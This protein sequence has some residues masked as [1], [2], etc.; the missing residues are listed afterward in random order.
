MWGPGVLISEEEEEGGIGF[1]FR[2]LGI[3]FGVWFCIQSLGTISFC[4]DHLMFRLPCGGS[5][6]IEVVLLQ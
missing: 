4:V 2:A 5:S 6:S 1:V 3:M